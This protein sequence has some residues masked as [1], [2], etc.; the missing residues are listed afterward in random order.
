MRIN[1]AKTQL[2]CI[3]DNCNAE[4]KSYVDIDEDIRIESEETIKIL[5]FVF[6]NRP[7]VSEHVK[8]LSKKFN[9]S[10]WVL[11]HL[12]RVGINQTVILNVYSSMLRP[13][14]GCF[15]P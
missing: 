15:S 7:N 8:H 3:S 14:C 12:I 11:S 5:G 9:N 1:D 6:G 4:V 10:I 13:L 2:L